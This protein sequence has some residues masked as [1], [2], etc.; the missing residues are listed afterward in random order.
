METPKPEGYTADS[1][2]WAPGSGTCLPPLPPARHLACLT[3]PA[4]PKPATGSCTNLKDK[5]ITFPGNLHLHFSY[6]LIKLE[7]FL[8][9]E[10]LLFLFYRDLSF[11]NLCPLSPWVRGLL[12]IVC[13]ALLNGGSP[14]HGGY[15]RN[16]SGSPP[17]GSLAL[18]G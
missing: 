13:R 16:P 9:G 1:A 11:H 14:V 17:L 7:V 2:T 10:R 12:L 18:A 15:P 4:T 6:F 8:Y 3:P 5:R